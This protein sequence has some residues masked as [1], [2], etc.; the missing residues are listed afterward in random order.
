MASQ[1]KIEYKNNGQLRIMAEAGVLLSRALDAA[2]AAVAPGVTT[3][4]IDA[5]FAEVVDA[6]GAQYNFLGYYG[7]PKH[8]CVSVND[9][10]VHG[11]PGSRV[12]QEGDLVSIDCGAI[13][14]GWHGDAALSLVV[15]GRETGRPEDLELID[16]TEDS[17]WAGIAALAVGESLYAVGAAVEDSLVSAGGRDGRVYGIV[18][19]YV[20]HGIGRAMHMDPQVPNYRVSGRGPRVVVGTTVAIEPMVTL[21]DQDNRVL[22]DDW[23]VVTLD[24]SRAAHWEHTV[25]VTDAGLWVLT[26]LDGGEERLGRG[27]AAYGPVER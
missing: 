14:D 8:I 19:D 24:G 9:E 5:V 22:A 16:A 2:V 26:A 27:G 15:G 21:G 23:T 10:V 25:A 6:A 12:L 18:E 3:D 20:G 11:I 4:E 17:M 1:R 7:Y 13:V